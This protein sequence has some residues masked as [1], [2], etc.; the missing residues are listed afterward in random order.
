MFSKNILNLIQAIQKLPSIGPRS[1][2]RIA[3]HLLLE[4]EFKTANLIV[5]YLSKAIASTQK[6]SICQMLSESEI[7]NICSD[8]Q[9]DA[10]AICIVSS[11][12][13]CIAI[14]NSGIFKGRYFV[15]GGLLSP[16]DGIGPQ[17]LGIDKLLAHIKNCNI[18]E[19][20][21]ATNTTVE[22]EATAYYLSE[23][24]KQFSSL[25]V[26]RLAQGIP[27]GGE[28]EYI[29]RDTLVHALD[30]RKSF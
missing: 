27:R 18:I 6:C 14:E 24:F 9:R 29:D 4:K 8:V 10:S 21:L 22:G 5:N 12:S 13:E 17:E 20:I 7:C 19:V 28:L 3:L 11:P 25:R 15:L 23:K 16:I 2:Q 26:S 30:S 1:A